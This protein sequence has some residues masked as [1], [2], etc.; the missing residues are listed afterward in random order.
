MAT[1]FFASQPETGYMDGGLSWFLRGK[2]QGEF[3]P[4]WPNQSGVSL[5]VDANSVT[6]VDIDNDGDLDAVIGVT[7]GQVRLL[8]NL[9][10]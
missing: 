8:K 9:S 3:E 7:G 2:G 10:Q 5:S 1:N 4:V 6:T